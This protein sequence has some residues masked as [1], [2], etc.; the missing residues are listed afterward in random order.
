M[1]IEIL[2]SKE[3]IKMFKTMPKK[4]AR[5]ERSAVNTTATAVNMLASKEASIEYNIKQSRIRKSGS[6]KLIRTKKARMG[7]SQ[8]SI[9]FGAKTRDRAN[10]GNF[11]SNR[12]KKNLKGGFKYKIRRSAS[13]KKLER[14]FFA[15]VKHGN[16]IVVQRDGDTKWK[17]RGPIIGRTGPSTKQ[18]VDDPKVFR[19]VKEQ[20]MNILNRKMGEAINKQLAKR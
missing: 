11:S 19:V 9:F 8:A 10:L 15:D 7:E 13:L 14:G 2:G 16:R 17:G 3:V 6:K 5:A 20:T 18:M 4:F 12:A 1:T